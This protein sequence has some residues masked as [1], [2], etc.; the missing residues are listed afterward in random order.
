MRTADF[1]RTVEFLRRRMEQLAV[2]AER[3]AAT[4]EEIAEALPVAAALVAD[5]EETLANSPYLHAVLAILDQEGLARAL[6]RT[7]RGAA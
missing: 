1:G 3:G 2:L 5:D 6:P 4:P 7:G